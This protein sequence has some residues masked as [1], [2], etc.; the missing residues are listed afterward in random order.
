M[1]RGQIACSKNCVSSR[2]SEL[3]QYGLTKSIQLIFKM[4]TT[5]ALVVKELTFLNPQM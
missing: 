2:N 1:D 4:R 5:P 3:V